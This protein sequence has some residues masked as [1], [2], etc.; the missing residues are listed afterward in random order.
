MS[1]SKE[2]EESKEDP[3]IRDRKSLVDSG[4]GVVPSFLAHVFV[5]L[6]LVFAVGVPLACASAMANKVGN[7]ISPPKKEKKKNDDV[8]EILANNTIVPPGERAYDVVLYGAT[9]FTGKLAALYISKQYGK[10]VKWAI[11]G[12][13]KDALEQVRAECL[14]A[15]TQLSAEDVPII[16]AD[17]TDYDSLVK[18]VAAT[19]VVCTTA[20]PFDKYGSDLVKACAG[21][22]LL[23]TF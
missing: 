6:P 1:G 16:L 9:G 12:R 8:V 2:S 20:G 14:H 13:R 5:V 18:M 7:I 22:S 21:K 17:S 15:N 19:R 10:S 4:Y 11:A 23:F 3:M